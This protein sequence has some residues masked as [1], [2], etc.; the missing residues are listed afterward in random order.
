MVCSFLPRP[1]GGRVAEEQVLLYPRP[2][3]CGPWPE[4]TGAEPTGLCFWFCSWARGVE[5]GEG[6]NPALLQTCQCNWPR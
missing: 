6:G 1:W 5:S 2:R 4:F 3:V